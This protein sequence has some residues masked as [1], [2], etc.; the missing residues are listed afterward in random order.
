MSRDLATEFTTDRTGIAYVIGCSVNHVNK[1]VAKG[2]PRARRG[3]YDIAQVVQWLLSDATS[4][5]GVDPDELPA[6]VEARTRLY[7][8]QEE[9]KRLETRRLAG[10]V[11]D[12]EEV[13]SE[14]MALAQ[15]LVSALEGVPMRAAQDLIG[16][17]SAAEAA[18]TLREHCSAARNE[19]AAQ[20]ASLAEPVPADEPIGA[21]AADPQR[22]TMGRRRANGATRKPTAGPVAE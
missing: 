21:A 7:V 2:M 11:I 12:A 9:H 16:V 8:A 5:A 6:V 18:A 13:R 1:L 10:E 20:L 19:L 14:M 3:Q 22:G 4:R 17:H 15:I